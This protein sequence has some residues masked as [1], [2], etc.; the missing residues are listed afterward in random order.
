MQKLIDWMS[1]DFAKKM[2]KITRNPWI[3]GVQ[4][5]IL[6]LMPV[7]LI[8]S[9]GTILGIVNELIPSFPDMSALSNFSFGLMSLFLAYLIPDAIMTRKRKRRVSKQAGLAGVALF[10]MI[11]NPTFTEEG[12]FVVNF[13]NMG[14]SGMIASLVAG[15]FVA[16]VMNLFA[17]KSFF[18]EDTAIPDFITV[19]FDTLI[20][21]TLIIL[22]GW[23]LTDLL[24]FDI[25]E[26]ILQLFSPLISVG[27]SFWGF[28]LI[29]FIG[30]AFLYSF[31]ISTWVIYP[32]MYAIT[33]QGFGDNA[34]LLA[35]GQAATN[36]HV[37]GATTFFT[38]GGGGMT[39]ALNIM[40]LKA[41][42]TKV[43]SIGKSTIVPSIAN[44]NEPIV[45]GAPITFN[46]ILMIP[47]WIN[48]LLAPILTYIVMY[49]GLVP[50]PTNIFGFWYLPGFISAYVQTGSIA[51][52]IFWFALFALSWIIY[53]P[54]FKVYDNQAYAEEQVTE[55]N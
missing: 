48:G 40:M 29:N 32:I 19:W 53:Y 2:N 27:Q 42:S 50:I 17:Q 13:G 6:T 38:I 1:G 21:I 15:I 10:L 26:M 28:V 46:P 39:L 18:G 31:G 34:A 47:M 41:R 11:I 43:R 7:I 45:F 3:A 49:I 20:P 25:F 37:D 51:G 4:D 44:I 16:F 54:F 23:V 22:T 33:M 12:Q 52:V 24:Q 36:I 30:Y 5:A 14:S 8:G 9:I 55:N 35:A